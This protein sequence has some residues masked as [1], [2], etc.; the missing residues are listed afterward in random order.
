MTQLSLNNA[1][2]SFAFTGVFAPHKRE[3]ASLPAVKVDPKKK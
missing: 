1:I 2:F 3:A